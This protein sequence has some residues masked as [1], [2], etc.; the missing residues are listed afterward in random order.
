[1]TFP[2]EHY[3][4]LRVFRTCTATYT[5][6][7]SRSLVSLICQALPASQPALRLGQR[8]GPFS[9]SSVT[10]MLSCQVPPGSWHHD[11]FTAAVCVSQTRLAASQRQKLQMS[12]SSIAAQLQKSNSKEISVWHCEE[13]VR[14]WMKFWLCTWAAMP[15]DMLIIFD[16]LHVFCWSR[17]LKICLGML[18]PPTQIQSCPSLWACS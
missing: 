3:S 1:M 15:S 14:T 7:K 6:V 4:L 2:L 10:G 5:P 13:Q 18:M 11:G 9:S 12:S 8:P 16:C 17:S